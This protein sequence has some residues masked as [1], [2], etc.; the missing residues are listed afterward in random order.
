LTLKYNPLTGVFDQVGITQP[1]S[2]TQNGYLTSTDWTTF[3]NKLD[4][5]RFNYIPQGNAEDPDISSWNLYRDTG[6]S[7]AASY[8]EQDITW[9]SVATGN[10]G[11]GINIAY[12][13][14]AAFNFATPDINVVSAT[15]VQ[16]RW[17]NG[18]TL[19]ANPSATQMKAAWDA[20]P[21][22]VAI[23]TCAITGTAGDR[24]YMTGS[25]IL[26]DGGDTSPV[27]ATGGTPSGGLTFTRTIVSPLV[28]TA[29]FLLSKDA[30]DCIGEGVA[31]DFTINSADKGNDLQLSFYYSAS[32]DF[33]FGNASDV[34][35]FIRDTTNDVDI[36]LSI[37]TLTGPTAGSIYRFAATFPASATSVNYRLAAHVA[38][39]NL[40]SWELR[41]DEITV[42]SVL[43]AAAATQVPSLVLP[44]QPISVAV[45]SGMAVA[46]IDGATSWVPATSAFNGDFWGM[47]GM[48]GNI[49]GLLADITV[50]GRFSENQSYGPFAGYNQ[51]IDPASA[52]GL[53]ALPS[54][55]TDRYVIMGKAISATELNVQP[56]LGNNLITGKGRL[57][58]NS[59][60][61]NGS[62]DQN[63]AVGGN[64]TVLVANS[65]ATLGINWAAA[66]VAAA[67]FTYTLATRTLTIAVSTN[68]VAG[69]LSAADHTTY[70]G[71][72]ATIA[73]KANI[74]APTFT[75]TVNSSTGSVLISTIGQGLGIKTG[76]NSKIGTAVLVAGVVTVANT[77]VNANSRIIVTGQTDGGTPGALRVSAKIVGTSFTITSSSATDTSTVAWVILESI[78]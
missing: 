20:V 46:W 43:D 36:P 59:G 49:V 55:F 66:V 56:Y 60:L 77:S 14:N 57:L 34:R 71:Y 6:R 19:A 18:P 48:A 72:A 5:S 73:L 16:I 39:Q 35:M 37:H 1:A 41:L 27:D 63:L 13:Y 26:A 53:T 33:V 65:A 21:A 52:G 22:A 8:E 30:T 51:Y 78:P 2:S 74:A 25:H 54:P 3:D 58:S 28:E 45:T 40:L 38:T 29:S 9:T 15:L 4:A 11:N 31:T 7:V 69:V 50:R 44:S 64:G 17:H 61:N 23:A 24:Q 62:G 76:V 12:V 32:A 47:F 70:S 10:T 67:P 42:N 68:A 75:G